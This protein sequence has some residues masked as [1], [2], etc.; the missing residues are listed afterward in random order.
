VGIV[1]LIGYHYYDRVSPNLGVKAG[2]WLKIFLVTA[3]LSLTTI[4][5]SIAMHNMVSA[6]F[7]F[8]EAFFFIM[9]LIVAPAVLIISLLGSLAVF[10]KG[11]WTSFSGVEQA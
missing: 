8:E 3:G 10:I 6:W 1:F 5:F 7:N 11:L 9:G 4:A 2:Q